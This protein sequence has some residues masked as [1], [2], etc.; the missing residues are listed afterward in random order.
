MNFY[1]ESWS[2]LEGPQRP[3]LSRKS[4]ARNQCFR[5]CRECGSKTPVPQERFSD[6]QEPVCLA[7]FEKQ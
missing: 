7:C 5:W 3:L 1:R 2:S 6:R 4:P